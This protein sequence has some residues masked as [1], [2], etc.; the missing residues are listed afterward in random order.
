MSNISGALTPG[1]GGP[2][3]S[4]GAG[5]AVP[6]WIRPGLA[7]RHEPVVAD[8]DDLAHLPEGLDREVSAALEVVPLLPPG[9]RRDQVR[10]VDRHHRRAEH[11]ARGVG[12]ADLEQRATAEA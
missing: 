3:D 2:S 11:E 10:I 6:Q 7:A 4:S 1:L 12:L 8:L 9:E 5:T